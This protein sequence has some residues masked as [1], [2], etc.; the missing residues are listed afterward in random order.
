[1][2]STNEARE[3]LWEEFAEMSDETIQHLI[4]LIKSV[5]DFVISTDDTTQSDK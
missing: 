1:M 3:L 5:C 2:L 4:T